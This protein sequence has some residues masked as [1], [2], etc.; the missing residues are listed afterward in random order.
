M[1][2][3]G[4]SA[5]GKSTIRHDQMR[6]ARKL[7]VPWE[8]F[9]VI[10]PDYWRKY[11]LDY[12]S[13][14]DDFK[15]AAMLTGKELEMID[16]KLDRYMAKKAERQQISHLLIDR[17]R[18]DSFLMEH[19]QAKDSNLLT[20]FGKLVFLFFVITEPSKTV[21]RA[22]QRGIKTGRYKA[23]DDLLYHNVEAYTGMPDLFFSW[24]SAEGKHIHYEFLDN[25]VGP[26]ERPRTVAFG[27]NKNMVIL[28][29]AVML[30][31]DRYRKVNVDAKRPADV[32]DDSVMP[33]AANTTFLERC[34]RLIET[35]TF[36]DPET[37]QVYGRM[38]GGKW[39]WRDIALLDEIAD[40]AEWVVGLRAIGWNDTADIP[41]PLIDGLDPAAEKAYTLGTWAPAIK[42]AIW[43]NDK[44]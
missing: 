32:F 9:A 5:A 42:A 23:V 20:R 41:S 2:V 44:E 34:V 17:F 15:Y 26:D 24:A 25:N 18:F 27:W 28:D 31:I 10:S 39:V 35:V 33:A 1:N 37:G 11:L 4:A 22:Y 40:D 19:E 36:A 12:A 16:V 8:T 6:L 14:G 3:K 13:L 30:N 29:V 38:Q 7:D 43:G 21:E